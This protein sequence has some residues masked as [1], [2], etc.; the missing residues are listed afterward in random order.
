MREI[1]SLSSSIDF[2]VDSAAGRR[3]RTIPGPNECV[4][5]GYPSAG[6]I[7]LGEFTGVELEWL[8]L[9]RSTATTFQE[10]LRQETEE[11]AFAFQLMRLGAR[12]WPSYEFRAR[13]DDVHY[14]Y[15]HHYPADLH[16]G[17]IEAEGKKNAVFLLKTFSNTSHHRLPEEDPPEK[18]NEWS[19]LANCVTMEERCAVLQ[20]FG[21][22]MWDNLDQCADIPQTLADGIAEGKRYEALM[23]KMEDLEYVDQWLMSL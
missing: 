6:G 8:G 22:T 17:Y 2:G 18:P 7:V 14:P 13:H 5:M 20:E 4:V 3:P 1:A 21:A 11:D 23:K 12:W 9:S 10:C 16:V 15:G 19:R